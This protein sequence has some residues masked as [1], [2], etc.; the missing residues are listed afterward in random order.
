MNYRDD[1][2]VLPPLLEKALRIR[3]GLFSFSGCKLVCK[4]GKRKKTGVSAANKALFS[5]ASPP[6]L[7]RLKA[8]QHYPRY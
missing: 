1:I 4:V 3:A 8:E 5:K 2:L 6:G 7:A